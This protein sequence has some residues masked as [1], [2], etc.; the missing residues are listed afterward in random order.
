M[1]QEIIG[2]M[3]ITPVPKVPASVRGVIDLRGRV[4]PV[5]DLRRRFGGEVPPDTERTC[6]V[7]TQVPG[8]HGPVRTGVIVEDV[9]EVVDLPADVVESV[10]ELGAGVQ[11]EYLLGLARHEGTVILLLDI[12]A[13]LYQ[14]TDQDRETHHRRATEVR[15]EA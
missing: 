3:P 12:E 6:V 2:L 4:I 5:V 14:A 1:V 11:A 7:I 10:P 8:Q 15:A 13:V 9:A